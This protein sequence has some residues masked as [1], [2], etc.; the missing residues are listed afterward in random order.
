MPESEYL[1]KSKDCENI[2]GSGSTDFDNVLHLCIDTLTGSFPAEQAMEHVLHYIGDFFAADIVCVSSATSSHVQMPCWCR[3]HVHIDIDPQFWDRVYGRVQTEESSKRSVEVLLREPLKLDG[4]SLILWVVNPRRYTDSVTVLKYLASFVSSHLMRLRA[5]SRLEE[6]RRKDSMTGLRNR[7]AF[8]EY[9]AKLQPEKMKSLGVLVADVDRLKQCNREFGSR[10]GDGIVLSLSE[11]LSSTFSPAPVFRVDGDEFVVLVP[12]AVYADFESRFESVRHRLD[13]K[14]PGAVSF[15]LTWSDKDIKPTLLLEHA[16]ELMDNAKQQHY[17]AGNA[18]TCGHGR[19]ALR[20]H[21]LRALSCGEFCMYLQPKINFATGRLSGA[22]ALVR[23]FDPSL[24]LIRP[25]QF[26]PFLEKENLIH[27]VDFFMLEQVCHTLQRWR[28]MGLPPIPISLNFSTATILNDQQICTLNRI[29]EE[30]DV[31]KKLV[32][33]EIA[34]NLSGMEREIVADIGRRLRSLGFCL[35]LDNFGSKFTSISLMSIMDFDSIKIDRALTLDIVDNM[36]SRALIQCVIQ[37]CRSLDV[38][39][40]AEGVETPEQ[41]EL[42]KELG[43]SSAQGYLLDCPIPL[44]EF[45][46]KYFVM[47][48]GKDGADENP[49]GH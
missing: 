6:A 24:G 15:G 8:N 2:T 3:E 30:H 40:I 9:L 36:R 23:R 44:N 11:S 12:D 32:Q 7:M 46:R 5:T 13:D 14:Y 38:E 19:T 43:C 20:V 47:D 35:S 48:A 37:A 17:D 28:K 22:E 16:D 31:D 27:H 25:D 33:I 49:V 39:S 1:K 10:W 29:C 45:E 18:P 34:E 26:I 21:L 4:G 42:L 41:L